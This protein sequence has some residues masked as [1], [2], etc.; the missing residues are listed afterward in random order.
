MARQSKGL[1]IGRNVISGTASFNNTLVSK[2]SFG[3]TFPRVP[4]VT[5]TMNDS[6]TLPPFRTVATTTSVTIRF[7][8][9]WTGEVDW[10][11]KER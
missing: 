2:V 9:A 10:E 4:F 11:A 7:A 5:I 8:S 3:I 6:G 1:C